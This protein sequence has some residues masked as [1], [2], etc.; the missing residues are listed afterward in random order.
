MGGWPV[1]LPLYAAGLA[2]GGAFSVLFTSGALP[3]VLGA[4]LLGLLVGS[5]GAYRFVLLFPSAALYTLVAVY[6]LPPLRLSGWKGLL[7]RAGQDFYVAA[8]VTYAN[9]VRSTC[10]L[11][12]SSS[13]FP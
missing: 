4:A 7:E 2:T 9:T 1:R 6:G 10:I 5:A 12:C 3:Y 13:S 11:V 8:Q